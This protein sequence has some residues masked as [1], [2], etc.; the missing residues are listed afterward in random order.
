MMFSQRQQLKMASLLEDRSEMNSD[1]AKAKKQ[2][3]MANLIRVLAEKAGAEER[4]R[5]A[6][7]T[8]GQ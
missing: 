3:A 8:I 4:R 6:P 2:I 1:P 5:L 7:L